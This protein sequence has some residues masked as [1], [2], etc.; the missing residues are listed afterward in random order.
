MNTSLFASDRFAPESH[1]DFLERGKTA[2]Q[3]AE[4]RREDR[5]REAAQI[6][7]QE[8]IAC[9]FLCDRPRWKDDMFPAEVAP[10]RFV[11]VDCTERLE[12]RA[13]S[14]RFASLAEVA[15]PLGIEGVA[16]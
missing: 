16:S 8:K 1:E 5:E 14:E 6:A 7:E 9:C 12:A 2:R 10:N 13:V 3:I 15:R 4:M 11:C